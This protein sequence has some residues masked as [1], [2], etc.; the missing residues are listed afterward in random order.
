MD[1]SARIYV[2]GHRGLAGSAILRTLI[3]R[4]YRNLLTRTHAQLDLTDQAAV[5]QFFRAE[6]PQYVFLAA[7]R[8]GGILANASRP[9][10]F[11][12]ENLAIQT[13]VLHEAWCTGVKKLL[14]LGSSCIYP[15]L[16]PQPLRES[17][18]LSGALETTNEAYAVAKIAGIKMCS[19]YNRQYGTDFL[20]V[21]PTN[22]F[23]PADNY[24]EH[25]SHVMAALIR[26]FHEAKTSAAESVP[27]WGTGMPRREFLYSDDLAEAGTMLMERS[28][29]CEIGELINIGYG[30]DITIRELAHTIARVVG[31]HG[32]LRFDTTKPDGTPR[33]LLD[34]SRINALGW[35]PRIPL[36]QGLRLAYA[37]FLKSRWAQTPSEE[38]QTA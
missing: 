9:A 31:F 37:D 5:R 21:Q 38:A 3:A 32:E 33:K 15:K 12:A 10:E 24:D 1:K 7:G 35:R 23:G 28:R 25:S 2:A 13:N 36:E 19:A 34:C 8:V 30:E 17:A 18:L 11:I 27:I 22:L 26:K 14:F 6:Q 4:G 29:A 16:A 20:C